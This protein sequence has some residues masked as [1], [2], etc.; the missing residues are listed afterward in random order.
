MKIMKN[1]TLKQLNKELK[2]RGIVFEEGPCDE[3]EVC[4][5]L[6]GMYDWGFTTI[7]YC[8]V[9]DPVIT[10]YDWRFQSICRIDLDEHTTYR[11]MHGVL[12][13]TITHLFTDRVDK[14]HYNLQYGAPVHVEDIDA[15][16]VDLSDLNPVSADRRFYVLKDGNILF[17]EDGVGFSLIDDDTMSSLVQEGFVLIDSDNYQSNVDVL[18]NEIVY[19]QLSASMQRKRW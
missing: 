17:K 12:S 7:T 11:V 2:N 15:I 16:G 5:H 1:M 3:Y 13:A 14:I 9:V 8:N 6:E 4:C 10:F 19:K 18:N